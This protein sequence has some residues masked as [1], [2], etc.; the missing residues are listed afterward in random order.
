MSVLDQRHLH[1][2]AIAGAVLIVTGAVRM[3]FVFTVPSFQLIF[4]GLLL[5]LFPFLPR[6]RLA[7]ER[8]GSWRRVVYIGLASWLFKVS[9]LVLALYLFPQAVLDIR[10]YQEFAERIAM[11]S[12]SLRQVWMEPLTPLLLAGLVKI[13]I[14]FYYIAVLLIPALSALTAVMYYY[15]FRIWYGNRVAWVGTLLFAFAPLQISMLQ[16]GMYRDIVATLLLLITLYFTFTGKRRFPL[17]T[18]ASAFALFLSHIVV[19]LV[20]VASVSVYAVLD[21]SSKGKMLLHLL[22]FLAG[23]WFGVLFI[24]EPKFFSW[25]AET[26]TSWSFADPWTFVGKLYFLRHAIGAT[27][28]LVLISLSAVLYDR[29]SQRRSNL[30]FAT[31]AG[32]GLLSLPLLVKGY[33]PSVPYFDND[34][35]PLFVL[36]HHIE[37]PLAI[38]AAASICNSSRSRSLLCVTLIL[39]IAGSLALATRYLYA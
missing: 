19:S 31:L 32:I 3:Y 13:G 33:T 25:I 27:P 34:Q 12:L 17:R 4:V 30:A 22:V 7:I 28:V 20:Y 1:W 8:L 36:W 5:L 26:V 39:M 23:I 6:G 2:L 14:P 11:N 18:I 16:I 10:F 38:Y 37:I 35:E 15:V 21:R 9:W 29:M 24:A